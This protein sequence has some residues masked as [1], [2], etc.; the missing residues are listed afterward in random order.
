VTLWAEV[1]GLRPRLTFADPLLG[2]QSSGFHLPE[3]VG[4]LLVRVYLLPDQYLYDP[5]SGNEVEP[6]SFGFAPLPYPAGMFGSNLAVEQPPSKRCTRWVSRH[7][8]S[9]GIAAQVIIR[10]PEVKRVRAI[11]PSPPNMRGRVLCPKKQRTLPLWR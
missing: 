4:R 7:S 2:N 3:C 5:I 6:D 1:Q 8:S 11:S 9:Q 10:S